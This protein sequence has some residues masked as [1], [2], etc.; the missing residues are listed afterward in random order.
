MKIKILLLLLLFIQNVFSQDVK[1][2]YLYSD[3]LQYFFIENGKW[4]RYFRGDEKSKSR[5]REI[6]N[7]KNGKR[8]G[9]FTYFSTTGEIKREGFY[10]NNKEHGEIITYDRKGDLSIVRNCV[11]GKT[12]ESKHYSFGKVSSNSKIDLKTNVEIIKEYDSNGNLNK[13]TN[14][15]GELENVKLFNKNGL[16]TNEFVLYQNK[17]IGKDIKYDIN[18]IRSIEEYLEDK[19]RIYTKYNSKDKSITVEGKYNERGAKVGTWKNY[20]NNKIYDIR[21]Y[22]NGK[23]NGTYKQFRSN[24]DLSEEGKYKDG[25]KDGEWIYYSRIDNKIDKTINY[26]NGVKI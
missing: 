7:F 14:K 17:R 21:S 10:L 18:G 23:L 16:L 1:E 26:N 13:T 20:Y 25:K 6:T 22:K 4:V 11:N 19:T 24:G 8:E 9:K 2:E 5:I 15:K 12:I 3:G